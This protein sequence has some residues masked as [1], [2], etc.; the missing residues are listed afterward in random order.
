VPD[1]QN[2]HLI[3]NNTIP[4][5]VR[6]RRHHLAHFGSRNHPA[7]MREIQETVCGVN[8]SAAT[9]AAA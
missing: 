4:D 8:N 9:F 1:T 2:D 7:P 6:I 5:D 3:V